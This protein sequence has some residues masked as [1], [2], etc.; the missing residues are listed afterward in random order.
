MAVKSIV[1]FPDPVLRTRATVDVDPLD[2]TTQ[3]LIQDLIDTAKKHG[4]WGLSAQQ[5]GQVARVAVVAKLWTDP[6]RARPV[7]PDWSPGAHP[8][9][10]CNPRLLGWVGGDTKREACMSLPGRAVD[11]WRPRKVTVAWV[12]EKGANRQG[13][14]SGWQGRA[15]QHEFDHLNGILIIDQSSKINR[16]TGERAA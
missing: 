3:E 1:L 9:V 16:M 13:I 15:L 6:R 4:A 7:A 12:D 5:L 8:I 10:L 14:F 2:P 11:I